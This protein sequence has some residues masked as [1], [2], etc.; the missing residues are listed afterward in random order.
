[1]SRCPPLAFT[2]VDLIIDAAD[3]PVTGVRP[4]MRVL[5]VVESLG[6]GVLGVVRVICDRLAGEGHDLA[7]AYGICSETSATIRDEID[8]RVE[9][10]TLPWGARSVANQVRT[11]RELRRLVAEWR[12]DVIHL[13]SSFAGVLG[14]A[15]LPREFPTV[16]SPHAYASK[17]PST[18]RVER[19]LYAAAERWVSRRVDVVGAVS[20]SEAS[21]AARM[22]GASRVTTI[23]N[24]IPE[25]DAP[26]ERRAP[27]PGRPR[28]VCMGR[29]VPLKRPRESAQ[30]LERLTDVA[31]VEW[32]G[33]GPES[34]REVGFLRAA[35]IPVT[36]WLDRPESLDRLRRATA[37]LHWSQW[38]GLALQILEAIAND[39]VVVASD[40][41]PNRDVV[42]AA[43][44]AGDEHE[45]VVML[46]RIAT[47][48]E[49]REVL[50]RAQRS[51][52]R[53]YGADR[54]VAE[55]SALYRRLSSRPR[56]PRGP[57]RTVAV[58][59]L[60]RLRARSSVILNYHGVGRAMPDEDPEFLW[61]APE[62]F[63]AQ[64]GC[65]HAAGFEFVTVADLARRARGGTPPP[66]LAALSFDDGMHDNHA[67]VLPLLEAWGVPATF[68]VSTGTIGRPN[69]WLSPSTKA[70]MMT[71]SE[72]RQLVRA[73]MELGAHTVTHPDLSQLSVDACVQEMEASRAELEQLTGAAVTTFAYPF[74]R[75][76]PEALEAVHRAGFAAA[77]TTQSRAAWA[78]HELPRVPI[79]GKDGL[80]SFVLKLSGR[81]EPLFDSPPGRVAR[82]TTRRARRR[83]RH[84]LQR[85]RAGTQTV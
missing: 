27:R 32:I 59:A 80:P 73:G 41:P 47:D 66:G 51:R 28:I 26:V 68:F 6:A 81:Y 42:G 74:G 75:Y 7:I 23:E 43:Q 31:D 1:V 49:Y 29:I 62:Q 45:A 76:G 83:A 36:G 37:Y 82:T 13:H 8:S 15:V 11:A 57:G 53:R 69:P 61:V 78:L 30:I 46:R 52:G 85:R 67:I 24:G 20:I 5:H 34:S 79:T 21:S 14:A 44:V 48:E 65:L 63:K 72:L 38:D 56:P 40:I 55:W 3:S 2:E 60:R 35:R 33:G 17:L 9:L 70:R 16:Y 77:V 39:V 12:P 18:G 71:S 84:R 64:V 4:Q 50:L 25:L 54:M 22:A 10:L 58:A 19:T